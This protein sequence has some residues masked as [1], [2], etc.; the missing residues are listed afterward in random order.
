MTGQEKAP[1][2]YYAPQSRAELAR[3]LTKDNKDWLLST[4][5]EDFRKKFGFTNAPR[6]TE[7]EI[8]AIYELSQQIDSAE[9]CRKVLDAIGKQLQG[10]ADELGELAPMLI[11]SG[12]G[13]SLKDVD[14][15]FHNRG[16]Q[17]LQKPPEGTLCRPDI[18]AYN[19]K[20]L[21]VTRSQHSLSTNT[22]SNTQ[23]DATS[24]QESVQSY[25]PVDDLT[26]AQT[27]ATSEYLSAQDTITS[28]LEKAISYTAIHL[29]A[30]PDRVVVPGFFFAPKYFFLIFTGATATCHT[31]L[32]WNNKEH[33]QLL[34]QFI[35]R[36]FNP[37]S[38][39]C[40]NNIVRNT[41]GTFD[42]VLKS[43]KYSGCKPLFYGRPVGRRTTIFE[44]ND[45]TVPVIKEQY[46]T[47]SSVEP[48]ILK[49]VSKVPGVIQLKDHEE[50]R[51][52]GESQIGS[53]EAPVGCTIKE[54]HR[55]KIRMTLRD[56]GVPIPESKTLKQLLIRLYDLLEIAEQLCRLGVLHRDYSPSNVLFREPEDGKEREAGDF[57]SARHLLD[58]AVERLATEVLLIDFEHAT[59]LVAQATLESAGTPL[60]QARAA[61]N[62]APLQ[63]TNILPGMPELIPE[64]LERYRIALPDRLEQFPAN[65]GKHL[66]E[67]W[68][69]DTREWYHELRHDVESIF[70]MLLH[71]VVVFRPEN[72]AG[73]ETADAE[74]TINS[75]N[76]TGPQESNAEPTT[77]QEA[78]AEPTIIRKPDM[79][80]SVIPSSFWGL[81]TDEA[82]R[83][84]LIDAVQE[85]KDPKDPWVHTAIDPVRELLKQMA[86]HL[87]GDTHW[88]SED[89]GY[90]KQMTNQSYLREVLQRL[91]LNFLFEHR[92]AGFME[93]KKGK[94]NRPIEK[95]P[96]PSV[97]LSAEVV[98]SRQS[99]TKSGSR[100]RAGEEMDRQGS[101]KKRRSNLAV[102]NNPDADYKPEK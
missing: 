19:Q 4:P 58:Q 49:Q 101:V 85:P 57:C 64:A 77:V 52:L 48:T 10:M 28:G 26:W 94:N 17:S 86:R 89:D 24:T 70:W 100:K 61:R 63:R 102:K 81:L 72:D 25:A 80:P 56:R 39:M 88:L 32:K 69:G 76:D 83:K 18:V 43:E 90:Y 7:A 79:E 27:E 3:A 97:P 14:V 96:Q 42:I 41:D 30:R 82:R 44:T 99:E 68:E 98:A 47:S 92:N 50:Y 78:D 45:P 55:Y 67:P 75:K 60:Y 54:K 29:L 87:D 51:P 8:T 1:R 40:D 74:P 46:L 12:K 35:E 15:K 66:V 84:H 34:S 23:S 59:T 13:S 2:S 65:K 5:V 20:R 91:I 37:S 6:R 62:M 95:V 71:W 9:S 38:D 93:L 21:L 36:I 11:E 73:P 22:R 33:L 31:Y 53:Q 16:S